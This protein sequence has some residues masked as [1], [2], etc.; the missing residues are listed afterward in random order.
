MTIYL[1]TEQNTLEKVN[2]YQF[3]FLPRFLHTTTLYS[4]LRTHFQQ[5]QKSKKFWILNVV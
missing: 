1:K 3:G 2:M 4:M 5:P